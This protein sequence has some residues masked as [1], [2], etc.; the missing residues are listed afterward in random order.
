[1]QHSAPDWGKAVEIS[2]K[3]IDIREAV[4][5]LPWGPR[6]SFWLLQYP[7]EAE[8]NRGDGSYD[9]G[10]KQR[11]PTAHISRAPAPDIGISASH[12]GVDSTI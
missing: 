7:A 1:M 2:M 12:T 10:T 4:I 5:F 9:S 8:V 6:P 3:L 11:G